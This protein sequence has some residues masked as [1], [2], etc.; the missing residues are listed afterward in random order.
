MPQILNLEQTVLLLEMEPPFDKRDVQLAHQQ[1]A[2]QWHP[3]IAPPNKQIKH[4]HHLKAI[5]KTTDMLSTMAKNSHNNRI[6]KNTMKVSTTTTHKHHTKKNT[7]AY[8]K[9]QRR[10]KETT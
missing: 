2:K 3:D 10:H 5:N 4:E 1:L 6:T 9:E 7:R 8:T